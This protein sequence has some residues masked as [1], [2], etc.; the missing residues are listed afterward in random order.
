M[1]KINNV[2]VVKCK[3]RHNNSLWIIILI[4]TILVYLTKVKRNRMFRLIWHL[5]LVFKAILPME[6]MVSK[7]MIRKNGW[8]EF[9]FIRKLN[10]LY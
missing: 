5:I 1:K 3:K 7:K 6:I 2:K 10:D 8:R 9:D 4:V